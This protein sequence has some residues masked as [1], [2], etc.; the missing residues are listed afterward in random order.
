L[1]ARQLKLRLDADAIQR[2][3]AFDQLATGS[4]ATTYA[5]W[6]R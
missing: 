4:S 2:G 5:A 6:R 1:Y 3:V